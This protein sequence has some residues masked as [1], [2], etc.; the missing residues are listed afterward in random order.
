[1]IRNRGKYF[2]AICWYLHQFEVP[3][4]TDE[5][6]CN[7]KRLFLKMYL[8]FCMNTILRCIIHFYFSQPVAVSIWTSCHNKY[9]ISELGVVKT[10][11]SLLLAVSQWQQFL[12]LFLKPISQRNITFWDGIYSRLYGIC[13]DLSFNNFSWKN[14]RM[15]VNNCFTVMLSTGCLN[16]N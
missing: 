2:W 6:S 5:R 12:N 14:I 7:G 16:R 8:T 13:W 3:E 1:M 11:V 15:W 10:L 9:Q 4:I